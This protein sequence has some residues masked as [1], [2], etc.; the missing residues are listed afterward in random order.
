MIYDWIKNRDHF[1]VEV[2][3]VE[4]GHVLVDMVSRRALLDGGQTF[5]RDVNAE[6]RQFAV[7]Y[8]T[9]SD[10]QAKEKTRTILSRLDK[11]GA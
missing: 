10:E 7:A 1:R 9:P 6:N 3:D 5:I 4:A 2:P 8:L 11:I